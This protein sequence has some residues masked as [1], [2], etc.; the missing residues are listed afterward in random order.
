M[1]MVACSTRI[2][3]NSLPNDIL[4]RLGG[5]GFDGCI[6]HEKKRVF[7]G[8][9]F[10]LGSSEVVLVLMFS[11]ARDAGTLAGLA[12]KRNMRKGNEVQT[13]TVYPHLQRKSERGRLASDSHRL[14]GGGAHS[15]CRVRGV[16]PPREG[17]G[18]LDKQELAI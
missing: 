2:P 16:Y 8:N 11:S 9:V 7:D 3:R 18:C 14:R 17:L 4:D 5:E 15:V 10:A 6:P 13:A 12:G 1:Y